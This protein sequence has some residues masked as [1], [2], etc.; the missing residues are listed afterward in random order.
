MKKRIEEI[1]TDDIIFSNTD[2]T[3]E[4]L[5]KNRLIQLICTH[6]ILSSQSEKTGYFSDE[7]LCL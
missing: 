7:F 4:E 3:A 2:K 6:L 5:P 1:N